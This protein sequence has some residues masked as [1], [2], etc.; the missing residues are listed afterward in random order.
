MKWNY[1]LKLNGVDPEKLHRTQKFIDNEILRRS[2]PLV[3]FDS[4]VL[5]DSGKFGTH[6]GT[7][8]I[9]YTAPYA[10][11]QYFAGKA[12]NQR[13]RKWVRRMWLSQRKQILKDARKMLNGR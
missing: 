11:R 3:P 4:G 5:K 1:R 7:G 6:P 9:R 12:S 2:N 13:G 8:I 10:K